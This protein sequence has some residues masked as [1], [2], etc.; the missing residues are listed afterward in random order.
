[1]EFSISDTRVIG[2]AEDKRELSPSSIKSRCFKS[3]RV[4]NETMK[5]LGEILGG[6]F[7]GVGE[8]K[9]FQSTM[10]RV[11]IGEVYSSLN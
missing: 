8:G 4:K 6:S 11:E 1:M 3:L 7:F 9:I 2:H 10:P 5:T